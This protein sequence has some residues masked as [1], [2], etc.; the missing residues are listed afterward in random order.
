MALWM[1]MDLMVHT[2]ICS[3]RKLRLTNLSLRPVKSCLM[4]CSIVRVM[5]A[6]ASNA[7]MS[8]RQ[9]GRA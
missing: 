2:G 7:V 3:L 8:Q 4:R 6:A 5:E 1:L 9:E